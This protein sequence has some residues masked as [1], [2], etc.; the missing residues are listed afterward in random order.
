MTMVPRTS[1]FTAIAVEFRKLGYA[2]G[3]AAFLFS[4]AA[5][6]PA[7]TLNCFSLTATNQNIRV[8]GDSEF[9]GDILLGCSGTGFTTPPGT[10]VSGADIT[11]SIPSTIITSKIING[12]DPNS[13][14]TPISEATLIVDDLKDQTCQ[15]TYPVQG[16]VFISGPNTGAACS[17]FF[18]GSRPHQVCNDLSNPGGWG[19]CQV[20]AKSSGPQDTYDGTVTALGANGCPS[21]LYNGKTACTNPNIFAGQPNG[22]GAIIFRGVPLDPPS[23][24]FTRY[25]RITNIR[26]NAAWTGLTAGNPLS[27]LTAIISFQGPA[28]VGLTTIQTTVASVLQGMGSTTVTADGSFLQCT[29]PTATLSNADASV[30]L[31]ETHGWSSACGTAAACAGLFSSQITVNTAYGGTQPVIK[32]QE[33]FQTGWKARN[34]SEY[35]GTNGTVDNQTVSANCPI[36]GTPCTNGSTDN[37]NVNSQQYYTYASGLNTYNPPDIAQ[38]NPQIRYFTEGGYSE[39]ASTAFHTTP[40]TSS[41]SYYAGPTS[42][43]AGVA[44]SGTRM[45]FTISSIPTGAVMSLPTVVV[46]KNGKI[47]SGVMVMISVAANGAGP[48]TR[49]LRLARF[50]L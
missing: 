47:A 2:V 19:V 46:L 14:G 11:I 5:S 25:I 9:V 23:L 10:L 42:P 4:F 34:M 38:N 3:L 26:V 28:A 36:L 17:Y 43:G 40:T 37:N 44:D 48:F 29:Y 15:P 41:F 31:A 33:G 24:G 18:P 32:I 27:Q 16:G 39:T 35:L 45:Q 30:P 7:Q 6:A 21:S 13:S 8:E 22:T 12:N 50:L 1:S 20:F 49:F